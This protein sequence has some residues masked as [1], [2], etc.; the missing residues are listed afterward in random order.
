MKKS[1]LFFSALLVPVDYLMIILAAV[2]AHGLR[3]TNFIANIRPIIFTLPFEEYLILTLLIAIGW[4]AI[5]AVF[6]LYIITGQRHLIDEIVKIFAACSTS[7]AAVIIFIFFQRELFS[8]RFI[9][10]AIWIFSCIFVSFGRIIMRKIQRY[11]YKKNYGT[12]KVIIVGADK[13]SDLIANE[14]KSDKS[15]G[16]EVIKKVNNFSEFKNGELPDEVIAA[17]ASL[18]NKEETM[19]LISYCNENHIGFKY[20][21]DIFK[22]TTNIE[23]GII[24]GVPIVELKETK[25]EGWGRIWKRM[26]DIA[27]SSFLLILLLP[28]FI[29]IAVCIKLD[30]KGS[31]F[32]F[33]N[34]VG[35][36]GKKFKYFKFR[37]MEE[38]SHNLR[39]DENFQKKYVNLRAGSPM[40]KLKNDPRVTMAGKFIRRYSLDELPELFNVFIGKMSLVGPRPHEVEEVTKYEKH[41]KKVLAIKPGMTGLAQISGR[42][43]LCFEEEIKLDTFYIEN[44][45]LALD[46]RILIKTPLALFKKRKTL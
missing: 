30:S 7:I 17:D 25:L 8:S 26:F 39:F 44:W 5:F 38:G 18:I 9:I 20:A 16:Y 19:E 22:P 34:R 29:I 3:F 6:K 41:H 43:D 15:L 4:L 23:I 33:Y 24:A 12:R 31:V 2:A 46:L 42:S 36:Y 21:A 28:L 35:E 13:T 1:E 10:I 40:I 37:S 27:I 11:L 14:L 32:F 45:S